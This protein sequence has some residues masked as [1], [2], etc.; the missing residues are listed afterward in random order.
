MTYASQL[1][2]TQ[3]SS[4]CASQKLIWLGLKKSRSDFF[5]PNKSAVLAYTSHIWDTSHILFKWPWEKEWVYKKN[6]WWLTKASSTLA[7]LS[8][9]IFREKGNSE[10]FLKKAFFREKGNSELFQK[11]LFQRKGQFWIFLKKDIFQRKGQFWT[12]SKMAIFREKGNSWILKGNFFVSFFIF[13]SH[14]MIN[15][16]MS[17]PCI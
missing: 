3:G 17:E 15:I 12:F 13:P 11:W 6:R 5:N 14:P 8:L 16:E 7:I 2:I 4:I 1:Y 10:L 9:A